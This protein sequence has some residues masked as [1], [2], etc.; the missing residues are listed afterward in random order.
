M[1]PFLSIIVPVYN[2]GNYLQGCVDSILCQKGCDFE[3]LLVDDGSTDGSEKICDDYA[4]EDSRIKVIHR[5]NGGASSA[6]NTGLRNASGEWVMFVDS[7]DMLCKDIL[8]FY[9]GRTLDRDTLYLFQAVRCRSSQSPDLWPAVFRKTRLTLAGTGFSDYETI[10]GLLIYGTPWGKLYNLGLIREKEI[11]FDERLSL[12]EDHCFFFRYL[13]E[14]KKIDVEDEIGYCYR[15]DDS[16]NS[17]SGSAQPAAKLLMAY[18]IMQEE[19][20]K[21]YEVNGWDKA[22]LDYVNSFVFY[23]KLKALKSAFRDNEPASLRLDILK[24]MPRDEISALYW[25][26]SGSA[27][28]LKRVLMC[29]SLVLKYIVLMVFRNKLK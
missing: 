15:V 12:H 26:G 11:F 19:L 28:M 4:S 8:S 3:L 29:K 10:I 20:D 17:M 13:S 25:T 22:R 5:K 23:I 6:R 9:S 14:T 16:G 1:S 18:H 27:C 2:A 7:D 24:E 21:I